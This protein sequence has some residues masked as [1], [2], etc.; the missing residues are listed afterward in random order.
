MSQV[1]ESCNS[2]GRMARRHGRAARVAVCG[3]NPHAGEHGMFS[4]AEEEELI[5]PAI[6]RARGMGINVTGPLPPDTAFDIR[7]VYAA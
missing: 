6:A 3:L 2:L 1:L 4:H 5:E 7:S